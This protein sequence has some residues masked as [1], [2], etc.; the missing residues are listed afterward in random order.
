M[1]N[2][3][4]APVG[5]RVEQSKAAHDVSPTQITPIQLLNFFAIRPTINFPAWTILLFT[6]GLCSL[7]G[8][9]SSGGGT[10]FLIAL[11]F[12]GIGVLGI[13]LAYQPLRDYQSRDTI[14]ERS[15]DSWISG[16]S[17]LTIQVA[18]QRMGIEESD[19]R[20]PGP[21]KV[22]I[23][24]PTGIIGTRESNIIPAHQR[25]TNLP[26]DK[27]T[28]FATIDQFVSLDGVRRWR[29]NSFIWLVPM[30]NHISAYERTLNIVSV[31]TV[32]SR[33]Q[34]ALGRNDEFA[35]TD[36]LSDYNYQSIAGVIS[37]QREVQNV[38][39]SYYFSL[40][41]VNSNSIDVNVAGDLSAEVKAFRTWIN[42]H[43]QRLQFGGVPG[44]P[45]TGGMYPP[46]NYP[47]QGYPPQ[48]NPSSPYPQGYP[49]PAYPPP[50]YPSSAPYPPDYAQPPSVPYNP[51]PGSMPGAYP[52]P[53]TPSASNDT[54]PPQSN[55]TQK[56]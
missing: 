45:P 56:P 17:A 55:T 33:S 32:D 14:T 12:I 39:T 8:A 36:Q 50:T 35:I 40:S 31:T 11:I 2:A 25:T 48:G 28:K 53:P 16:Q 27:Q 3:S 41:I 38:G 15:F 23:R 4:R 46:Q 22:V 19:F 42:D 18:C 30:Q 10:F 1:N 43:K 52:T 6:L 9:G 54:H 21:D 20:N 26:G 7:S 34:V 5:Y 51:Q 29:V 37:G 44:M 49:P 24:Q 13:Y 47:P